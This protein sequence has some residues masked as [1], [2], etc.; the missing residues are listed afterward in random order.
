MALNTSI[1]GNDS[2]ATAILVAPLP[3]L[4]THDSEISLLSMLGGDSTALT[5]G[6]DTMRNLYHSDVEARMSHLGAGLATPRDFLDLLLC[7]V[8]FGRA[9]ANL[10]ELVR[11][12][13]VVIAHHFADVAGGQAL[14]ADLEADVVADGG[15]TGGVGPVATGLQQC[16]AT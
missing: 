7:E 14:F 4:A 8:A 16:D 3:I 5:D 10:L 15:A 11:V 13:V 12:P 2:T 9:G 6:H 1:A